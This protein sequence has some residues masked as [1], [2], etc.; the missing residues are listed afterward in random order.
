MSRRLL[1]DGD[2]LPALMQRV[3]TEMGPDAV[4]VKAERVR[5]GGVAGFFAKERFEV[6]VE[7]PD[8]PARPSRPT[9]APA[10]P[11]A[12]G[13]SALL[14]AADAADLDGEAGPSGPAA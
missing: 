1:L 14:D 10:R 12:V 4:V 5:T 2:D 9:P 6:T 13:M 7:V 3:R 8:S 11:A